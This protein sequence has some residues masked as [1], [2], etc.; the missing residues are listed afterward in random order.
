MKQLL[1]LIETSL[2][3]D[4]FGIPIKDEEGHAIGAFEIMQDQTDIK[5]AQREAQ[6]QAEAVKLQINIAKKQAQYQNKEVEKLIASLDKFSNGHL[7]ITTRVE[8]EDTRELEKCLDFS[9]LS[10]LKIN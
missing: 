6:K 2:D 1:V 7:D 3:I 8:D 9:I 4:Y 5:R 10:I